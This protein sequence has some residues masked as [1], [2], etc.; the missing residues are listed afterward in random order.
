MGGFS[1]TQLSSPL[2]GRGL[3]PRHHR[4]KLEGW[5]VRNPP[6]DQEGLACVVLCVNGVPPQR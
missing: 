5:L 4:Q 3:L 1:S 2:G 6:L